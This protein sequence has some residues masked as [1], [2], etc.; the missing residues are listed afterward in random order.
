MN[1]IK[2]ILIFGPPGSGKGTM[3]SILSLTPSLIHL[4]SGN[5]FRSLDNSPFKKKA[6]KYCDKGELIPD[7]LTMDICQ[8]HI[9]FLIEE[10]TFD[11]QYSTLLLDGLPRTLM[12]AEM[13]NGFV[14]VIRIINLSVESEKELIIRLK[15]RASLEGRNDDIDEKVIKKRFQEYKEKTQIVL[16]FYHQKLISHINAH[17]K[18]LKVLKDILN[19]NIRYLA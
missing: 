8:S 15:N 10:G 9:N 19:D 14:E 6:Q 17:Q 5:I 13:L 3:S 16:S 12:Q 1:R 11:K 18:P 4:S 2:S 7:D